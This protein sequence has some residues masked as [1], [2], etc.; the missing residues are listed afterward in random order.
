MT[1]TPLLVA[2]GANVVAALVVAGSWLAAAG[3]VRVVDQLTWLSVGSL[4]VLV[5]AAADAALV[6]ALRRRVGARVTDLRS[7]AAPPSPGADGRGSLVV[8][9]PASVV[10]VV[11]EGGRLAHEP[12]CALAAG[13]PVHPAPVDAPACPVCRQ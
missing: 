8:A 12:T 9:P 10:W 3:R 13:K 4:A 11:V 1:G 7:W 6:V 2:V 5:A